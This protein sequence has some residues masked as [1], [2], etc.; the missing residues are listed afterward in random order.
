MPKIAVEAPSE[1]ELRYRIR[2][3]LAHRRDD[4]VALVWRGYLAA[5]VEWGLISLSCHD[6]LSA[7]LPKVGIAT[8]KEVFLGL[9][10]E[11]EPAS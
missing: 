9:P 8:V 6:R 4:S 1:L 5:L 3:H 7:M 2:T 11:D 10:D